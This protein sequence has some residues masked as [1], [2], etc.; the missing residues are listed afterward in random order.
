MSSAIFSSSSTIKIFCLFTIKSVSFL[1]QLYDGHAG[2][3]FAEGAKAEGL[4]MLLTAQV[5]MD[6]V[7]QRAGSLAVNDTD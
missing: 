5:G 6:A 3:A 2:V 7:S 1:F 4:D